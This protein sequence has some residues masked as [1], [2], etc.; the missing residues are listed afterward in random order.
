LVFINKKSNQTGLK[1]T[2]TEL[3]PVQTN[4]FWFSYLRTKTGSNQFG[5]VFLVWL[6][7]FRF[8]SVIYKIEP[9]DFKKIIIDFFYSLIFSIIFFSFL[10][11][12][13]FSHLKS[14][15]QSDYKAS[16]HTR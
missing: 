16:V 5:L 10:G 13:V 7:F 15:L 2:E 9:V 3:E 4:R 6:K 8:G 12:S 11:F 1:K 14:F